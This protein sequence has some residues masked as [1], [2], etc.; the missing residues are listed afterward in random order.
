MDGYEKKSQ[1]KLLSDIDRKVHLS[2]EHA[3]FQIF[4]T[5]FVD[6]MNYLLADYEN[7]LLKEIKFIILNH[8]KISYRVII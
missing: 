8:L 3:N 4:L 1:N 5:N 2:V 6:F 7:M